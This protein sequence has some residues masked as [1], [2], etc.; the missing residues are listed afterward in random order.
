[1]T[2]NFYDD[3]AVK[4][5]AKKNVKQIFKELNDTKVCYQYF[6]FARNDIPTSHHQFSTNNNL[7]THLFQKPM[8]HAHIH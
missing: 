2:A 8:R 6:D 4:S 3:V 5:I 1:M 7:L